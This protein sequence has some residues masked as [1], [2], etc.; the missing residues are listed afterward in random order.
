M[1]CLSLAS[2]LRQRGWDCVF[3]SVEGTREA[4]PAIERSGY[5]MVS[6]PTEESA[7]LEVLGARFKEGVALVVVDHYGLGKSFE[8]ACRAWARTVMVL[9]DLPERQHDADLLLDQ[10]FGRQA[11]EYANVV[12]QT[13]AVFADADFALLREEFVAHR[14]AALERRDAESS[15]HRVL[16]TMGATDAD[17][18]T[19]LVLQ[20]IAD[21]SCTVAVDVVM[22][23]GAP[24]LEKVKAQVADLSGV[25][26]WVDVDHIARLMSGA[27][28]AV[29]AGG[30]TSWERCCLGLPTLAVTVAD[31][32]ATI[33]QNLAQAGAVR[34]LGVTR[35]VTPAKISAALDELCADPQALKS[36]SQVARTICD[37]SGG[38]RLVDYL[39][40]YR[41]VSEPTVP[42]ER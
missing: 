6:L 15:L 33:N 29:G 23:A 12:P 19:E 39:D 21:S 1:R 7:Q 17:N 37:G 14:Q 2:A 30:S 38:E 25:Y 27:D 42:M 24:H 20:G 5:K 4:V 36:M 35:E 18:V 9:D 28:L 22:G 10:S 41:H 16:I 3:A 40:Q 13:C 11:S 34:H 26:L 8:S 31:N 32:Q